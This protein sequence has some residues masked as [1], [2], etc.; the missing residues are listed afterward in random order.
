VS[1]LVLMHRVLS[2]CFTAWSTGLHT[3]DGS[4]SPLLAALGLCTLCSRLVVLLVLPPLVVYWLLRK[5]ASM[6]RLSATKSS[7]R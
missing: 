3:P 6:A 2:W 5:A 4:V 1:L 7:Q